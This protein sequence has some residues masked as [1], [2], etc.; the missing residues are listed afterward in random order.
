MNRAVQ[1]VLFVLMR[2]ARVTAR[3]INTVTK[4]SASAD[5]IKFV[6]KKE[7]SANNDELKVA[8]I[9]LCN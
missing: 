2:P 7:A 4:Q 5:F 3:R 1:I 9:E 6:Q 8:E